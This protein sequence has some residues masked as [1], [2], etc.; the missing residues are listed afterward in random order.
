M[1][2]LNG[3]GTGVRSEPA[4]FPLPAGIGLSRLRVYDSVGPDGLRGGSPH[5]HLVCNEAYVVLG[6]KGAV[7]VIGPDGFQE[8]PVE[9]GSL[10]WFRPGLVHRLVNHGDLEIE[11]VMQIARLPEA[12]DCILSFPGDVM[13]DA[14]AYN[15]AAGHAPDGSVAAANDE[16]ARSRRDLAVEGFVELKEAVEREGPAALERFHRRALARA[17]DR[18]PAWVD[19]WRQGPLAAAE[20]AGRQLEALQAGDPSHLMDTSALL[21]EPPD[22]I[23]LGMCGRLHMY[24]WEEGVP[25]HENL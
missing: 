2:A 10:L 19:E 3:S 17:A 5:I 21:I 18:L 6:G 4:A 9:D 25:V 1:D 11:V 24:P 14:D 22:S 7:Q 16:I 13:D 8:I 15:R 20:T 23:R 12:G